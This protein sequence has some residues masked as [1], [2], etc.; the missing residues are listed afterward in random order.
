MNCRRIEEL[1]PLFVGDDLDNDERVLVAS[2]AANCAS[3]RVSIERYEESRDWL[4]SSDIPEL[5][6]ATLAG[7][8]HDIMRRLNARPQRF[9]FPLRV[10]LMQGAFAA[11]LL[12]AIVTGLIYFQRLKPKAQDLQVAGVELDDSSHS[13]SDKNVMIPEEDSGAHRG[14]HRRIR[15]RPH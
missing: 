8:R 14:P 1:I 11:L 12:L 5:D 7:F 3:C 4:A 2:H 9:V 13:V 6:E 10:N 15:Q